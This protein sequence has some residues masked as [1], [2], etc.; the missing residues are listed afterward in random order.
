MHT[1]RLKNHP[2]SLTAA[3]A[4]LTGLLA[5][6]FASPAHAASI[7][8]TKGGDYTDPTVWS[9]NAV[10]SSDNDYTIG[11]AIQFPA[12]ASAGHTFAGNSLTLGASSTLVIRPAAGLV[13]ISDLRIGGNSGQ[14]QNWNNGTARLAGKITVTSYG[15]INP[16]SNR[17]IE[18]SSLIQGTGYLN[19]RNGIVQL[20]S[21]N[22]TYSGGTDIVF[23]SGGNGR[24]EVLAD[25]ALGTGK[26]HLIDP[27]VSLKLSGGATNNYINDNADLILNA[28]LAAGAVDLSFVGTDIIGRLSLDGGATWITS[29]TYGSLASDAQN[30]LAVFAGSGILQIGTSNIPEVSTSALV[31]ALAVISVAFIFRRRRA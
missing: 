27:G 11:H 29:G 8:S 18:I 14:I 12:N 19:I 17:T 10:P 16:T 5:A 30:K 28:G 31:A 25:G 13:T 26:V 7:T 15:I 23:N 24:L 4:V 22:N 20:T 3:L 6:T 2:R 1:T 21:A 9:N